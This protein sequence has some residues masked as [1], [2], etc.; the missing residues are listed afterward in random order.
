MSW[1]HQDTVEVQFPQRDLRYSL[2]DAR[3]SADWTNFPVDSVGLRDADQLDG[4][5][6]PSGDGSVSLDSDVINVVI[7]PDRRSGM[8]H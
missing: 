5:Q 2:S 7:W 1:M 4:V 8:S 3:P 6:R